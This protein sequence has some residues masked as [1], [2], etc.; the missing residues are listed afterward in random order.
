M[1]SGVESM[2]N[3]VQTLPAI[4]TGLLGL[5]DHLFSLQ[6]TL[7]RREAK[8][9]PLRVMDWF[10][11]PLLKFFRWLHVFLPIFQGLGWSGC[12]M[13]LCRRFGEKNTRHKTINQI[14]GHLGDMGRTIARENPLI[15][16]GFRCHVRFQVCQKSQEVLSSR[17]FQRQGRSISQNAFGRGNSN[18]KQ[19]SVSPWF[20]FFNRSS[21]A[22]SASR[23]ALNTPALCSSFIEGEVS[24]ARN[25]ST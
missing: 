8:A 1:D 10:W 25:T 9:R 4:E 5:S 3:S 13:L 17:G 12:N 23:F 6:A 16:G 24:S 18:L 7:P 2:L 14:I 19:A 11:M 22:K 21:H 15:P 20:R